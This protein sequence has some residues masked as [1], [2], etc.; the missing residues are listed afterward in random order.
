MICPQCQAAM[1]HL[2]DLPS[3]RGFEFDLYGCP[4]CGSHAMACFCVASSVG[5]TEPV[6]RE[7]AATILKSEGA[8]LQQF[9]RAWHARVIGD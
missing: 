4:R 5:N 2:A 8:Q 1:A 6:T 9:M 3:V 7:E